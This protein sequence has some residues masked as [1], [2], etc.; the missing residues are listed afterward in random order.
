MAERG[1]QTDLRGSK[2]PARLEHAIAGVDVFAARSNIGAALDGSGDADTVVGR[3]HIFLRDHRVAALGHRRSGEDAHRLARPQH[4][5][6]CG[7]GLDPGDHGERDGRRGGVDS[8]HGVTV[9]RRI[10]PRRDDAA[11]NDR[12]GQYPTEGGT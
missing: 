9:H 7:A 8:A 11:G 12:L 1:E 4:V 10:R 3:F 2:G 6:G 5:V